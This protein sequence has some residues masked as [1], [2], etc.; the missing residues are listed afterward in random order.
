MINTTQS[1]GL[2][3]PEQP[4]QTT[5][6]QNTSKFGFK[7]MLEILKTSD[8]PELL[9]AARQLEEQLEAY[10]AQPKEVEQDVQASASHTTVQK[11][12]YPEP[13]TTLEH[14]AKDEMGMREALTPEAA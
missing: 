1:M 2:Y 3:T 9:A 7:E 14:L 12:E 10:R 5:A 8:N 6:P 13:S 4:V 11:E